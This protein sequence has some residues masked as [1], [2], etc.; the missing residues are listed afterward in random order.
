VARLLVCLAALSGLVGDVLWV[1]PPYQD[2][3]AYRQAPPCPAGGP[4]PGSGCVGRD[5]GTVLAKDTGER[6]SSYSTGDGTSDHESCTT[7]YR[8]QLR[9]AGD[10]DWLEVDEDIYEAARQHDTAELSTW[11]G[12]IVRVALRGHTEEYG[13]PAENTVVLRLALLWLLLGLAIWAVG[14]GYLGT[15]IAFPNFGWLLMAVALGL[16]GHG[17]LLGFS[18]MDWFALLFLAPFFFIWI[19][20]AWWISGAGQGRWWR[21][22]SPRSRR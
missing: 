12:D 3:V 6:C 11:H 17:L 5:T 15:L 1:V 7:Y 18:G 8:L 9:R 10:T 22:G 21:P 16:V 20:A 4:G 14:S 2:V 19:R 13:A